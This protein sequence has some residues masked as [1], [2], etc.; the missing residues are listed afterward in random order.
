MVVVRCCGHKE[1]VGVFTVVG[2]VYC[3]CSFSVWKLFRIWLMVYIYITIHFA[4]CTWLWAFP[5]A[6]ECSHFPYAILWAFPLCF[7]FETFCLLVSLLTCTFVDVWALPHAHGRSHEPFRAWSDFEDWGSIP[8]SLYH[9][10][11]QFTL[12]NEQWKW[13][14]RINLL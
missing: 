5:L 2:G 1:S 9:S 10:C 12:V 11:F 4:F 3:G 13:Y 14:Y 8:V 6:C 7:T